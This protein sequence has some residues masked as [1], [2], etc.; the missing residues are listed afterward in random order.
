MIYKFHCSN[1]NIDHDLDI[2]IDKYMDLKEKQFCPFCKK[3]L[4][5]VIEWNGT[6]SGYG[7][8]WFGKSNG[9]KAI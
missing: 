7:D 2:P 1:C 9:G 8:G 5:R 4:I 6:A 3:K